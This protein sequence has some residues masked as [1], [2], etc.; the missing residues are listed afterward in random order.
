MIEEICKKAGLDDEETDVFFGNDILETE[1]FLSLTEDELK[2]LGFTIGKR[3]KIMLEILRHK[4]CAQIVKALE[5]IDFLKD[6]KDS[7][8]FAYFLLTVDLKKHNR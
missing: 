1:I 3:K 8:S 7:F 6:E 4:Q 5:Q 2:E